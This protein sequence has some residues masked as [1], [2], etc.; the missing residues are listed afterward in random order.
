M[1]AIA[2]LCETRINSCILVYLVGGDLAGGF[3][4]CGD[5]S[6]RCFHGVVDLVE[7]TYVTS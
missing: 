2:T 6:S 1:V 5:S 4:E 3:E 7:S